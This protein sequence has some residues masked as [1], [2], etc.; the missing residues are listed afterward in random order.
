MKNKI[1][2]CLGGSTMCLLIIGSMIL[3][4]LEVYGIF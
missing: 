1:F 4:M 2:S 3:W